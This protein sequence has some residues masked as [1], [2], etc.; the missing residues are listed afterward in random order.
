MKTSISDALRI[1][2][3][4]V[5]MFLII[6]SIFFAFNWLC[7]NGIVLF[8]ELKSRTNF[9]TFWLLFLVI[10]TSIVFLIR[11]I[12]SYAS[13]MIVN[14]FSKICPLWRYKFS[15]RYTIVLCVLSITCLMYGFWNGSNEFD[16]RFWTASAILLWANWKL[17]ASLIRGLK[18]FNQL[19]LNNLFYGR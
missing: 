5:V 6:P 7:V 14:L 1:I 18:A 3:Y 9:I 8:F 13:I 17:A 19:E 10:G 16:F 15:E 4:A 11:Y 2:I 12:F